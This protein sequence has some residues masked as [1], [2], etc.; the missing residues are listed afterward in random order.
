MRRGFLTLELLLTLFAARAVEGATTTQGGPF[1]KGGLASET[2]VEFSKLTHIQVLFTSDEVRDQ[3]TQSLDGTLEGR[4]ALEH[5]LE[6]TSLENHFLNPHTV[7]VRAR[8]HPRI[9]PSID[10]I[11][12]QGGLDQPAIA[13]GPYTFRKVPDDFPE[14]GLLSLPDVMRQYTEAG[15]VCDD[16]L[17][18]TRDA[19]SNSARACSIDL[20]MLGT[21]ETLVVVD[22][23]RLAPSGTVGLLTD[24]TQV[25]LAG[26]ESIDMTQDMSSA[27][28]GSDGIAGVV[29]FHLR[30]EF[31]GLETHLTS[32][33]GLGGAASEAK[34][35]LL[36]GLPFSDFSGVAVLEYTHRDALPADRRA[37][38][39]S[40]LVRFGGDNFN[41]AFGDPGNA[42]FPSIVYAI[43]AVPR[44]TKL[45]AADFIPNTLNEYDTRT[46]TNLMPRED[47]WSGLM[48][49][50]RT[51][52]DVDVF[53][54]GL[55]T[56]RITQ[57]KTS[58]VSVSLVVPPTNAFYLYPPGGTGPE[59]LDLGFLPELG[60][61][62][63][64]DS[65]WDGNFAVGA[66]FEPG[67]GIRVRTFLSEAFEHLNENVGTINPVGLATALA[68]SIPAQALDPY[69]LDMTSAAT[70]NS[71][72]GQ[73]V[74]ISD[75]TVTQFNVVADG[76]ASLATRGVE[77]TGG[78]DWR[79]E[80]VDES[81]QASGTASTQQTNL[82]RTVT[83]VFG[84]LC[85]PLV[86]PELRICGDRDD[87][88][89][90]P[91]DLVLSGRYEDFSDVGS[92]F[93]PT[94]TFVWKASHDLT[95]N[96]SAG[97]SRRV[98]SLVD[99]SELHNTSTTA[100]LPDPRSPSTYTQTLVW[101]G[102]NENL[103]P[104]RATSGTVTV[105]WTPESIPL[106]SARIHGYYID[107]RDRIDEPEYS[108]TA[109]SDNTLQGI[110]TRAPTPADVERVCNRSQYP[111][112]L[113]AC[114][115]SA[116]EAI[117]DVR[118]QNLNRVITDGVDLDLEQAWD[119]S[120]GRWTAQLHESY[121]DRWELEQGA[122]R[123]E[124]ANTLGNALR[125]R[126]NGAVGWHRGNFSVMF[127]ANYFGGYHDT[128]QPSRSIR[129]W[130]TND[131][132][133][134]W[135]FTD[136]APSILANTEISLGAHNVFKVSPPFAN[137][138]SGIGADPANSDQLGRL[139]ML[140]LGKRF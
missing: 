81:A 69:Q 140:K 79:R 133:L 101:S 108:T 124:L 76:G 17:Q 136:D 85:L 127:S 75:S 42:I 36:S 117:L 3:T 98:A 135:K 113:D 16:G 54:D 70:W 132:L 109:L 72:K 14:A 63:L 87:A 115:N 111:G 19:R 20:R 46:S 122:V 74:N 116:P 58:A 130:L 52:G 12:V 107:F 96:V 44:G 83:A 97:E 22:G 27:L 139:F 114:L 2:L 123:Q 112:G 106:F 121:V 95:M 91:L 66:N 138:S 65:V 94:V 28:H 119:T 84:T 125:E 68:S 71:I 56:H 23:R 11:T 24:L 29:N 32:V 10:V 128:N 104:E 15:S 100:L 64:V 88:R 82:A 26:V 5:M 33:P 34:W 126:A 8:P 48:S 80:S 92:H 120:M 118:V 31:Q 73:S 53:V 6:T 78:L 39:T 50:H 21:S 129:S 30:R 45:T 37:E 77:F 105:L 60:P 110:I 1:L 90:R 43:P 7:I 103:K 35:S 57:D 137:N 59:V 55:L 41:T 67:T 102:G 18:T 61:T 86:A 131:V 9:P 62:T 13:P 40:D 4:Q 38:G 89:S 93:T 134:E 47:I 99:L 51:I 25:P 49:G